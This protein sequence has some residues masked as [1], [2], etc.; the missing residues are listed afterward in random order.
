MGASLCHW[1]LQR[2]TGVGIYASNSK[3]SRKENK[4]NYTIMNSNKH[5]NNVGREVG[6]I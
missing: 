3:L 1:I 4:L 2:E 6:P 5:I